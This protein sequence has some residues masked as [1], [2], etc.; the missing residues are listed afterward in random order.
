MEKYLNQRVTA[1]AQ[2]YFEV[3]PSLIEKGLVMDWSGRSNEEFLS[4]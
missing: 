4:S 2:L 3:S 1:I